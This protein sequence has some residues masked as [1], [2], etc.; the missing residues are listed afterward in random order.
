MLSFLGGPSLRLQA[1]AQ[2]KEGDLEALFQ[3]R[4]STVLWECLLG[5]ST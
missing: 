3:L 1:D 4:G 5:L 2:H